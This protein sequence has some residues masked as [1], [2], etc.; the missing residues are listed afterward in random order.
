MPYAQVKVGSELFFSDDTGFVLIP[1]TD[2]ES[3]S[4]IRLGYHPLQFDLKNP[5]DTLL[6][7]GKPHRLPEIV[8]S[9][10]PE[11]FEVGYHK[12]PV[13]GHAAGLKH[14]MG[15]VLENPYSEALVRSVIVRTK[16]NRKGYVYEI[17]IFKTDKNSHPTDCIFK[18]KFTTN[19]GSNRILF[20]IQSSIIKIDHKDEILVAIRWLYS[21]K[22]SSNIEPKLKHTRDEPKELSYIF[23]KNQWHQ[24]IKGSDLEYSLN[25]QIGLELILL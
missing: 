24:T 15:V 18:N 23:Y 6:M 14:P 25:Y 10:S 22:K 7:L 20:P 3:G 16:G 4:V 2:S 17:S 1:N 19:T 8:I 9:D 11:V 21:E 12:M 13:V 5:P